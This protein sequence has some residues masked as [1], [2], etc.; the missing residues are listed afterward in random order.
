MT[1]G[2]IPPDFVQ[3]VRDV[4]TH[5]YDTAHL[6]RHPLVAHLVPADLGEPRARAQ[7]LRETVIQCIGALRPPAGVSPHHPA[8]RPY[9]ILRGKYVE[10]STSE[11]LQARLAIGRRQL[12]REQRKAIESIAS[13]LWEKRLHQPRSSPANHA[14]VL[15]DELEQFGLQDQILAL[16]SIL[17]EAIGAVSNLAASRGVRISLEV[18]ESPEAI[19]DEAISRQLLISLMASLVQQNNHS[20]IEVELTSD[21]RWALLSFRA[22]AAGAGSM[23]TLLLTPGR[24]AHHLGGQLTVESNDAGFLVQLRLPSV[25]EETVAIVDDNPRTLR[26]FERFLEPYHYRPVLIRDS[27]AALSEIRSLQP[28]AVILDIMMRD[29]DGW[30]ILQSLRTDPGTRD[31][32]VLVCSVLNDA[33]LA[34]SLGAS[35]YIRKPVSQ[36]ELVR[37]LDRVRQ[38][39]GAGPGRPDTP[40]RASG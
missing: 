31:I 13:V 19:A 12:F 11:E 38:A 30:A 6:Q 17:R 10:G 36:G 29:V 26:L 23:E 37:A 25:E 32:P 40:R 22:D 5:L 4:L 24:L 8:Y 7:Y 39:R 2:G 28:E 16:E 33:E 15:R 20:D 3:Q 9:N 14:E 35:A 21:G 27:T 34:H 18:R 1:S